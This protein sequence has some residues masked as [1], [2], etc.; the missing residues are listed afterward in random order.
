MR[1]REIL[2]DALGH[3][4]R[5]LAYPFGAFDASVRQAALET[6]YRSACSVVPRLAR[7]ADDA[8]ALPRVPVSGRDTLL[9]FACRLRTARRLKDLVRAGLGRIRGTL[10]STG[11]RL[12][13]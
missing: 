1:S 10:R 4:I 8:L 7:L 2:E 13:Q 12:P 3:A 5:D 11:T 6:G 9:D